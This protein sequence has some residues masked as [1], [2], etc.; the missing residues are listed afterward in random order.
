MSD[1]KQVTLDKEKILSQIKSLAS[2][3]KNNAWK[4]E[5]DPE[6]DELIFGKDYM[7]RDAFLFNVND[8]INLFLSPDS[9]V[10]GIHIEYFKANFLEHNQE[11]KP[12]LKEIEDNEN[13]SE[14]PGE[15]HNA[16][17]ALETELVADTFKSLFSKDTLVTAI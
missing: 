3:A 12:V 7:P 4:F 17:V 5:Y 9:S 15:A 13:I 8:E 14:Q 11:L 16:K 6:I 10:N 2:V 1:P